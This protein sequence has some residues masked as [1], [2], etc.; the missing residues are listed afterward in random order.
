MG[1]AL[2]AAIERR[3]GSAVVSGSSR[4][5]GGVD[6]AARVQLADGRKLFVKVHAR[7]PRGM[8]GCEAEGLR[9]LAETGALPVAEV[10]AVSDGEDGGPAFIALALIESAPRARDYEERLG[11][12]L[13]ALHRSGAP[14]F[15]FARDN[16]IAVLAQDNSTAPDWPTFYAQRRLL[17]QLELAARHG[18][19]SKAM[20]A[21]IER[22]CARMP[23]LCG[24][25]EPPA[26]L[27]GDLW[28][29]N[30]IANERGEPV[31]IDPAVYGGHREIDLAMMQLFGGFGARCFAAYDEAYPLAPGHEERV[32][33]YQLY[34]LLVH[35]NLFGGG[36]AASVERIAQRYA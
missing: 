9:W 15:G 33:L 4:T 20:R 7:P 34:P 21:G 35:V 19:A 32:G 5:G 36:Y 26:R 28:A 10:L 18:R 12:G 31:L 2:H 1:S 14:S 13:A 8:Y 25:P 22:V 3:L 17:P 24:P 6:G 16:F 27:H 29:G 23:E 30:A 11:R